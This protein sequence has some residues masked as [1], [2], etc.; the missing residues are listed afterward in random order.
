MSDPIEEI[1]R[2]AVSLHQAGDLVAAHKV[3][4]QL[5]E[6]APD[7]PEGLNLHG[8]VSGQLGR[9]WEAVTSLQLATKLAPGN[10]AYQQNL[11]LALINAGRLME[12]EQPLRLAIYLAPGLAQARANLGNV[13]KQQ[14]RYAEAAACYEK[15]LQLSPADC[16][17]WN[18]LGTTRRELKDLANAESC[19]RKS[20]AIKPDFTEALSNL[21]VV[22]AETGRLQEALACYEQAL[23]DRTP[24]RTPESSDLYLN[25]GNALRDVGREQDASAA[26]MYAAVHLE[27]DNGAAWS[28][29]GNA[30]LALGNNEYAGECYRRAVELHPQDPAI[31]FNLALYLLLNGDLKDGFAEY[32]WGLRGDMRQP[33]RPF[34]QP[35]WRGEEFR[36][37]TLLVYAEQGIGDMLQFVRFLPLVK[38]RGGYVILE[39]QQG[40]G[41]LLE[42]IEGADQVFERADDGKIPHAFDRYVALLSL[43]TLLG[44]ELDNCSAPVPYIAVS[45]EL[46]AAARER[47][48]GEPGFKVALSWYG[49]PAHKND[50]NRSCP[51]EMLAPLFDIPGISWYALS[52][53]ERTRKDITATGL[54]LR[55]LEMPFPE[56]AAV[57]EQMDLVI[58]VDSAPV[59][60]AGALGRPVWAMLP[61]S[62]DWRWLLERTDSPW[63]PSVCLFRQWR[64]GDWAGVVEKLTEALRAR[65]SCT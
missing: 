53:G 30:A 6:T 61:F 5:I 45:E 27:P 19:L 42:G 32:E 11:G 9:K 28:S 15:A 20:L 21:G 38:E 24:G 13:Y 62:P 34:R 40:L 51:L 18:N 39:V 46:R 58:S 26:F 59:H 36:G 55:A 60:L 3:Y 44:I 50:R 31:H 37:E 4:T 64:P 35:R 14:K 7:F 63:Y 54:P 49:N 12:A 29:L 8:V 52:P 41:P 1:M 22:L 2:R 23:G 47:L 10:A 57:M 43:P 33:R 16:K 17:T 25:Y 48:T 65:V 56:A